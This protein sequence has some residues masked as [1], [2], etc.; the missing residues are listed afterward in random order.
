[1]KLVRFSTLR[2]TFHIVSSAPMRTARLPL[3]LLA[4]GLLVVT[5]AC[6]SDTMPR[7]TTRPPRRHGG[8]TAATTAATDTA[9]PADTAARTTRPP[10]R[11]RSGRPGLRRTGL[12][13]HAAPRVLPERDPRA[14]GHR[15]PRPG[16]ST[17]PSAR[18]PR[19]RPR[20]STPAPRPSRRSSPTPSTPPSSARTR[21]STPSPRPTARPCASCP[22]PR[23]AAPRSS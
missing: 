18:P 19:S 21:P 6:G 8:D 7:P 22:A 23:R 10:R 13:R 2:N 1:M 3:A 17:M 15:R 4:A 14:G 16:F 20:P 12:R 5:A 11:H 9:A